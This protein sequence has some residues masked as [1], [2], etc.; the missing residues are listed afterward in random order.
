MRRGLIVGVDIR[1]TRLVNTEKINRPLL[2][3]RVARR[4]CETLARLDTAM[5]T[6]QFGLLAILDFCGKRINAGGS[7][8][9]TRYQ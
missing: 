4:R 6:H 9:A 2:S 8:P 1:T 7:E 5:C 3:K